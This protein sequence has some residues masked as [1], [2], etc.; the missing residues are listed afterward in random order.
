MKGMQRRICKLQGACAEN[1]YEISMPFADDHAAFFRVCAVFQGSTYTKPRSFVL[2]GRFDASETLFPAKHS[3]LAVNSVRPF[4]DDGN[5]SFGADRNPQ[6][7]YSSGGE[8]LVTDEHPCDIFVPN[9]H[10]CLSFHDDHDDHAELCHDVPGMNERRFEDDVT[11][12]LEIASD[13]WCGARCPFPLLA[14][15]CDLWSIWELSKLYINGIMLF[16]AFVGLASSSYENFAYLKE[17]ARGRRLFLVPPLGE[18]SYALKWQALSLC[19]NLSILEFD[20]SIEENEGE[21]HRLDGLALLIFLCRAQGIH[22]LALG[23]LCNWRIRRDERLRSPARARWHGRRFAWKTSRNTATRRLIACFLLF[24]LLGSEAAGIST[25]LADVP[26][27]DIDGQ[28]AWNNV[29]QPFRPYEVSAA[30]G[31]TSR[32]EGYSVHFG[33][34]TNFEEISRQ[35]AGSGSS[36]DPSCGYCAPGD[37]RANSALRAECNFEPIF[38]E[39]NITFVANPRSGER[40]NTE[41]F[42]NGE[43]TATPH[44]EADS[45]T[46]LGE[47]EVD[48]SSLMHQVSDFRRSEPFAIACERGRPLWPALQLSR[49]AFTP[50]WFQEGR[51]IG[52]EFFRSAQGV[53]QKKVLGWKFLTYEQEIGT[54]FGIHLLQ[55]GL[56][57]AQLITPFEDEDVLVVF[58]V[59]VTP[60]PLLTFH[61]EHD[62][63]MHD[64]VVLAMNPETFASDHIHL[65]IQYAIEGTLIQNALRCPVSP[66]MICVALGLQEQCQDPWRVRAY[67]RIEQIERVFWDYERIGLPNGAFAHLSFHPSEDT[68]VPEPFLQFPLREHEMLIRP[69][70]DDAHSAIWELETDQVGMMQVSPP[71]PDLVMRYIAEFGAFDDT[72]GIVSWLHMDVMI[73]R[74]ASVWQRAQYSNRFPGGLFV[75]GIWDRALATQSCYVF[76]EGPVPNFIVTNFEGETLF[77]TLLLYVTEADRRLFTFVFQVQRWPTMLEVF[78][79][80]VPGHGCVWDSDCSIRMGPYDAERTLVWDM[81]VAL[82]EGAYLRLQEF[83]RGQIAVPVAADPGTTCGETESG[84]SSDGSDS[85]ES[86]ST[87]D[88]PENNPNDTGGTGEHGDEIELRQHAV[89]LMQYAWEIEMAKDEADFLAGAQALSGN[90]LDDAKYPEMLFLKVQNGMEE[91]SKADELQHYLRT[92]FPVHEL[93]TFTVHFWI[94]DTEIATFARVLPLFSGRSMTDSMRREL[95]HSDESESFWVSAIDPMPSPLTL[96]ICPLDLVVLSAKQKS[97]H[98]RIYVVDILFR[99]L[100]RRVALIYHHGERLQDLVRRAGLQEACMRHHCILSKTTTFQVQTWQLHEIV[101]ERHGTSFELHFHEKKGVE[102]CNPDETVLV[103]QPVIRSSMMH[104]IGQYLRAWNLGDKGLTIWYHSSLGMQVQEHPWVLEY[105]SSED[106]KRHAVD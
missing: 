44:G 67:F 103:Q 85:W 17:W 43:N 27:G 98:K 14:F 10:R 87:F 63:G 104:T 94:V 62:R 23:L 77:P 47:V 36:I 19:L 83:R 79:A 76:P 75:R 25:R 106:L 39:W 64:T 69:D 15:Y 46:V 68:C 89:N 29:Q 8:G 49:R 100:P 71:I 22:L 45:T 12:V 20:V 41:D 95:Q 34:E 91:E 18:L 4:W 78:D 28:T 90:I 81:Q 105:D 48:V 37:R 59:V 92:R 35:D 82:Y 84:S 32:I 57:A 96:R 74:T 6:P 16:G 55:R 72:I 13:T 38:V 73:D 56:W 31:D 21:S 86:G 93:P 9:G 1:G 58:F 60:Q 7:S 51:D 54:P 102:V 2:T 53:W 42:T 5:L 97:D 11:D 66:V 70:F 24:N 65:V 52:F 61:V 88:S 30:E 101:D 50:I 33:V 99:S 3:F 80:T 26:R 40:T